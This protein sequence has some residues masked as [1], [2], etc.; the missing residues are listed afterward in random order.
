MPCSSCG[1]AVAALQ[2][3]AVANDALNDA[4][5]APPSSATSCA[6]FTQ[7]KRAN[8]LANPSR[9]PG[10]RPRR[11]NRFRKLSPCN[12][13]VDP[14][15]ARLAESLLSGT[16]CKRVCRTPS[17]FTANTAREAEE[18]CYSLGFKDA[19]ADANSN[20][21]GR[22]GICTQGLGG[23]GDQQRFG[24]L[25]TLS[26]NLLQRPYRWCRQPSIFTCDSDACNASLCVE[27]GASNVLP[28]QN[29]R[30]YSGRCTA[31]LGAG[32]GPGDK[33]YQDICVRVTRFG[34]SA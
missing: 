26:R 22:G 2:S 34:N 4:Q 6:Q 23:G 1:V 8:L 3:N 29:Q 32:R 20:S 30:S 25:C 13:Q 21:R 33:T 17:L 12:E 11:G 27:I 16:D 5:P 19:L 28:T 15:T 10:L 24:Q 7:L 18:E 14:L 9:R 31:G